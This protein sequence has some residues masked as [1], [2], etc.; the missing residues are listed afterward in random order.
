MRATAALVF[1][2]AM[3]TS[4]YLIRDERDRI[5]IGYAANPKA[6]LRELQCATAD[7]LTLIRV[8]VGAGHPTERWLHRKFRH[9]RLSGEWFHFSPEM[10]HIVPPDEIP[11][12]RP[13]ET[14]EHRSRDIGEHIREADR[15]G[16]L[17]SELRRYYAPLLEA[18]K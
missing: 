2:E 18:R 17:S 3:A 14:T 8:F 1:G 13:I 12:P 11:A 9:L 16:L 10:L 15:L 4:V 6:R 5:K 7:R